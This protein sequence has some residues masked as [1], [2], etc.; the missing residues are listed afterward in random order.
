MPGVITTNLQTLVDWGRK[1]SIWYMLFG[2]ACRAVELVAGGATRYDMDK[3]FPRQSEVLAGTVTGKMAP[4]INTLYNQ[5]AAPRRVTA[6]A[7]RIIR[8]AMLSMVSVS[9]RA[10]LSFIQS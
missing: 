1:S 2:T 6:T 10:R 9:F 8:I 3:G 5:M 7:G 4:H